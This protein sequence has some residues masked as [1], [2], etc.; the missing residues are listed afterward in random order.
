MSTWRA[1]LPDTGSPVNLV[2]EATLSD[3]MRGQIKPY[4]GGRLRN[5]GWWPIRPKGRLTL[6]FKF[7]RYPDEYE[8]EFLVLKKELGPR[9]D[10]LLGYPWLSK[11]DFDLQKGPKEGE[12]IDLR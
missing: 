6:K 11:N 10:C 7:A 3:T 5:L 1:C 9:F 4:R 2:N 12:V 8:A